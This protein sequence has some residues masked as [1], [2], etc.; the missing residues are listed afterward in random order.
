MNYRN[1]LIAVLFVSSM[2]TTV[3][4]QE[5]PVLESE[6][7]TPTAPAETQGPPVPAE[8]ASDRQGKNEERG[9]RSGE[10]SGERTGERS[11]KRDGSRR[12]RSS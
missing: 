1:S 12:N 6:V 4:A 5:P 8:Q 10:H 9:T 11:G 7:I 2:S 3:I